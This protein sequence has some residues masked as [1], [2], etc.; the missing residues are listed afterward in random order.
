MPQKIYSEA[1]SFCFNRGAEGWARNVNKELESSGEAHSFI[2]QHLKE[3]RQAKVSIQFVN[4]ES[5]M[6]A[7]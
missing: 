6:T 7:N 3:K 4:S 5:S 2:R 1:S